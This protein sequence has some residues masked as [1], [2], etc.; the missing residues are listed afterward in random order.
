MVYRSRARPW[1]L[2]LVL[3]T[4]LVFLVPAWMPMRPF[5]GVAYAAPE[6]PI[7]LFPCLV[8]AAL[9]LVLSIRRYFFRKMRGSSVKPD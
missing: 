1:R 4:I 8:V 6:F 7:K 3:L 9:G 5:L 2:T